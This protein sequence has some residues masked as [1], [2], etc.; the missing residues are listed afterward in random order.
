MREAAKLE[1]EAI[2]AE[3]IA[4]AKDAAK[5]VAGELEAQIIAEAE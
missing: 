5:L 2:K 1:A 4:E 3:I